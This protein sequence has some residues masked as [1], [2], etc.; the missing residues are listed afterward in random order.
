MADASLQ[1]SLGGAGGDP[2]ASLGDIVTALQNGNRNSSLLIQTITQLFPRV[3]GSF[4]LSAAATTVVTQTAVKANSMIV[5]TPTNASAG[6]LQGSNKCLY[7]S[8]KTVG[9]SFTVATASAAAAAG[10]E[11]FDYFVFT[12]G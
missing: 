1:A 12:P 11:T 2:G 6:T 8:A 3:T 5:L 9:A 7:V 10:T 4:T